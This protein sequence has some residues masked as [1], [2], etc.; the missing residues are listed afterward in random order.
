MYTGKCPFFMI[1][2]AEISY[3]VS[4]DGTV[5]ANIT[6]L[7]GKTIITHCTDNIWNNITRNMCEKVPE[8]GKFER[9]IILTY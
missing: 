6:C 4:V 3:N 9:L 5:I 1:D 8:N 2:S 7:D